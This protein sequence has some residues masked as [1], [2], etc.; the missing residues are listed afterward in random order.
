MKDILTTKFD[1]SSQIE[2]RGLR[3]GITIG[4]REEGESLWVN[5]IKQNALYLARMFSQSPRGH[6]VMLVN[7]TTVHVTNSLPWD[8]KTF[9]TYSF[10]DVKDELDVL[11]ELGGQIS[12]E[13]TAWLRASG[14][15]IVSYCCGPEYVQNMEAMIFSRGD[16]GI[17]I[18]EGYD[19]IWVI[20]QIVETSWH[21]FSTLRRKPVRAVPFVWDPM[22]LEAQASGLPDG[23]TYRPRVGPRRLTV[24]E[25]NFD[26]L[27][28]CLYPMLIADCAFRQIGEEIG[29]LNVTNSEHLAKYSAMFAS[30]AHTLDMVR[31][32]RAS[33]LG[34]FDTPQFL[35]NHS[36][37][38]ISH[39]WGL[40]LNYFYFDVCWQGYPLV[41]NAHLCRDLGY[42]YP[43]NNIEEGARQLV[44]AVR[45]HDESWEAYRKKQRD[46]IGA[47]LATNPDVVRVYDALLDQLVTSPATQ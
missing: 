6:R 41:H 31:T 29:Y 14:T 12:A 33:F 4:L 24:M 35:A 7:T 27:K 11:I 3:I 21:F 45:H 34:R 40:A 46:V 42:F 8:Q 18:N 30:I 23:G 43:D 2:R 10:T 39:Q 1:F 37:I 9:P 15:R 25:P 47:Y 32:H 38:V 13:Q 36:D 5:G 22:C 26:V 28:F 44:R 17:F 19:E 20:P 16:G